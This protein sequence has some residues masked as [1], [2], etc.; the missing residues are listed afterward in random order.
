MNLLH[1]STIPEPGF[2]VPISEKVLSKRYKGK[3]R[4]RNKD[5]DFIKIDWNKRFKDVVS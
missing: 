4:P 1:V 5:Y 3:G 2:W